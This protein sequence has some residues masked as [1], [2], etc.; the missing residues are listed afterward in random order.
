MYNL[1]IE[2]LEILHLDEYGVLAW[3][4]EVI[5]HRGITDEDVYYTAQVLVDRYKINTE[6]YDVIVGYRADDSYTRVIDAFLKN[7]LT[8]DEMERFFH[9]GNLGE[10]VFIKS[11]KAFDALIFAGSETVM[12]KERYAG[13]DI[14]ARREVESFLNNRHRAIQIENYQPQGLTAHEVIRTQYEYNSEYNFYEHR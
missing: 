13:Y 12:E 14:A 3:V 8:V 10:Q 1:D 4:A 11:Q 6:Y 7:Q 9:K 5:A 2:G